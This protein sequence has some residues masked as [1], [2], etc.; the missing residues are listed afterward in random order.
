MKC[1]LNVSIFVH[2]LNAAIKTFKIASNAACNDLK[3]NVILHLSLLILIYKILENDSDCGYNSYKERSPCEGSQMISKSPLDGNQYS[4]WLVTTLSLIRSMASKVPQT[5]RAASNEKLDC[6]NPCDNPEESE[7]F[8]K[9]H[10]GAFLGGFH[11]SNKGS[12]LES[13][14]AKSIDVNSGEDPPEHDWSTEKVSTEWH[15]GDQS[16]V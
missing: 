12:L 4:I 6:N 15:E 1:D 13:N 10:S 3:N 14:L 8:I 16:I 9:E 2:E 7:H 11:C 5:N